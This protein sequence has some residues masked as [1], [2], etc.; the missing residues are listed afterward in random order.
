MKKFI[1]CTTALVICFISSFGQFH[2]DTI[3]TK[4]VFGGYQFYQN[5]AR[6]TMGQMVRIMKPNDMAYEEIKSAQT[7]NT[8]STVL[9]GVGGFMFGWSVGTALGGGEPNWTLAGI[10]AGLAI[11]S[12]PLSKKS[13]NQAISAVRLYNEGMLTSSVYGK[14]NLLL[15]TTPD[16]VGLTL[17]F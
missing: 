5:E 3:V 11:I 14:P 4:K 7:N 15:G 17:R 6:L 2:K 12:I 10:G 13:A 16:G 9:G 8:I 1:I